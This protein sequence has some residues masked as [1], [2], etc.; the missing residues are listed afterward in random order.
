MIE[1]D[2]QGWGSYLYNK[3]KL[4][5]SCYWRHK[6]ASGR[7]VYLK[8]I[9]FLCKYFKYDTVRTYTDIATDYVLYIKVFGLH[10]G[11]IHNEN[12]TA[13][14]EDDHHLNLFDE[15]YFL[16]GK[17]YSKEGWESELTNNKLDRLGV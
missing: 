4:K 15:K 3:N 5:T 13:V 17:E 6:D 1:D 9:K 2:S 14:R 7:E 8:F 16:F 12:G 11:V 10:T